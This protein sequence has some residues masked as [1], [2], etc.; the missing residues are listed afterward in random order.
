MSAAVASEVTGTVDPT[1]GALTITAS[2]STPEK[3]QAVAKAYSQAYVNQIQ[4]LVNNQSEKIT[5][6]LA[7]LTPEARRARIPAVQLA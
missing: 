6:V 4:T 2:A 3:A 7:G 1:T 5:T